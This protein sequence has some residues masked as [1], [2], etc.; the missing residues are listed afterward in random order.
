MKRIHFKNIKSTHLYAKEH[1]T[2]FKAP[3]TVITADFQTGGIGRK[4]DMWHATEKS[5]LLL[6][7]VYDTPHESYLPYLSQMCARA[8]KDALSSLHLPIT[9]K[10][11]N[12]LMIYNKKLS[13][14]IS[15]IS[16]NQTITSCGLNI[17]QTEQEL[18]HI[19]Q[20]ATSLYIET[21][22]K[23]SSEKILQTLLQ[24]FFSLF[25]KSSV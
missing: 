15:E 25:S 4:G 1:L 2:E 10:Y 17:L 18:S 19:D 9:L 22:K 6:S 5:S 20:P 23:L 24:H 11:P 12:D 3:L 16:G 7:F 8:L 21:G 13:G 14:I